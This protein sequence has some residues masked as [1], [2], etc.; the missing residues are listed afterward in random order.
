MNN[1]PIDDILLFTKV[2]EYKTLIEAAKNLDV[3][4]STLSRLIQRLEEKLGHPLV[5]VSKSGLQLTSF[6][7]QIYFRFTPYNRQLQ[8]EMVELF[9]NVN[10]Y[11]GVI[12]VLVPIMILSI[13]TPERIQSFL[14]RHPGLRINIETHTVEIYNTDNYS[15][16]DLIITTKLPDNSQYYINKLGTIKSQLFCSKKYIDTYGFPATIEELCKHSDRVVA[17]KQPVILTHNISGVTQLIT[18]V[19]IITSATIP[20]FEFINSNKFI[21]EGLQYKRLKREGHQAVASDYYLNEYTGYML[22][23]QLRRNNIVD[24]LEQELIDIMRQGLSPG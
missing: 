4:Q 18:N 19:P 1:Y 21:V 24:K 9:T 12:N 23:S 8:Q 13:W 17:I 22:K 5:V 16:F 20:L 14:E 11:R 3:S 10:D 15:R 7:E 6:G 2:M